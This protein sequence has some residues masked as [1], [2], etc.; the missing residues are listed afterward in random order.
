[1]HLSLTTFLFETINFLVLLWILKRIVY[2]PLAEGITRRRQEL[3][4]REAQAAQRL[5]QAQLQSAE[6]ERGLQHLSELRAE[7][8]RQATEEGAEA[9]ARLLEQAREDAALERARGERLLDAE[10]EAAASWLRETAVNRSTD[11]AG[12][13]L[14]DLAP[15]SIESALFE[16]LL[17]ELGRHTER[18][19]AAEG[20]EAG[21]VVE[22]EVTFTRVPPDDRLERLR[23]RLTELIGKAPSLVLREDPTLEAGAVLRARHWVFDASLAGQLRAFRE[24]AR[25]LLEGAEAAAQ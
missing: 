7:T 19:R 21:P 8:V 13:L 6:V 2:R 24:R 12:R 17:G 16:R 15:E 20:A 25:E 18:L 4:D 10:R 9:R 11:V 1:M 3:L 5:A 23:S 22:I 14:L